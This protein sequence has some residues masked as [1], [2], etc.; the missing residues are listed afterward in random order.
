MATAYMGLCTHWLSCAVLDTCRN[1]IGR[2]P[3]SC[4]MQF[5]L[6]VS[7]WFCR[8]VFVTALMLW[9]VLPVDACHTSGQ[10]H[11]AALSC[12]C[13]DMGCVGFGSGR[14]CLGPFGLQA[15][16]RSFSGDGAPPHS[17]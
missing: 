17:S 5:G 9:K 1:G 16:L 12:M 4:V 2:V 14:R 8:T 3:A 13:R 6:K 7:T 15:P 10:Q 11:N